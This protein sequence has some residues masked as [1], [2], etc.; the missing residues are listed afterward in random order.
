M[1]AIAKT[2]GQFCKLVFVVD[3]KLAIPRQ[4]VSELNAMTKNVE[5]LALSN[6][7]FVQSSMERNIWDKVW[8]M[9]WHIFVHHIDD[10][11]WFLKVDDDT[12]FSAVQFKGFAQYLNP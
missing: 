12:F 11:E 2:W 8:K 3:D 4:V 5:I 7:Q 6:L 9:W 10:A 1:K